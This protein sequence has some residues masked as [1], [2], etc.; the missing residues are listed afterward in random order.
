MFHHDLMR[1]VMSS[2]SRHHFSLPFRSTAW[3]ALFEFI[4]IE[5]DTQMGRELLHHPRERS[6]HKAF[7][8]PK[9]THVTVIA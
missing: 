2:L 1:S 8:L 5:S 4:L 3:E 6:V 7:L 9:L